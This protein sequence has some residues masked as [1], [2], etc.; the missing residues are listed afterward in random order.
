MVEKRKSY[1]AEYKMRAVLESLQ[2]ETT[3]EQVCQKYKI[4]ASVLNRWRKKFQ[5]KAT[6]IF[7]DQRNP[8]DKA[9]TQGYKPGESPEDLKRLIGELVVENDILKKA[10]G[11]LGLK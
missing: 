6:A 7:L 5:E 9:Q 8:K 3:L 2:R 11:L 4:S 10:S 1:K